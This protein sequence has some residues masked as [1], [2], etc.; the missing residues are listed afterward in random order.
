MVSWPELAAPRNKWKPTPTHFGY[1]RRVRR[2]GKDDADLV[3]DCFRASISPN[4]EKHVPIRE[5][6]EGS[7]IQR[8][9]RILR[10]L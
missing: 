2:G 6:L 4:T 10:A 9:E 1:E 7:R 3:Y 5:S 8:E